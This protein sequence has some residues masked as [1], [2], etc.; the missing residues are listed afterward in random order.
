MVFRF[1]FIKLVGRCTKRFFLNIV[2]FGN[3]PLQIIPMD[4]EF[5]IIPMLMSFFKILF[6]II[7]LLTFLLSQY[8]PF[9]WRNFLCMFV[10]E[11]FTTHIFQQHF[12]FLYVTNRFWEGNRY[13]LKQLKNFS[14]KHF[15]LIFIINYELFNPTLN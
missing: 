14:T 13:F 9:H 7:L 6:D 12:L 15:C 10:H 5:P 11:P 4:L 1:F 2:T 8:W 3:S